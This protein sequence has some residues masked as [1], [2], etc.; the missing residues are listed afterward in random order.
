M[1][2]FMA[3]FTRRESVHCLSKIFIPFY[4]NNC[5][6]ICSQHTVSTNSNLPDLKKIAQPSRLSPVRFLKTPL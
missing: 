4:V 6:Q 2:T 3:S 5:I 1:I